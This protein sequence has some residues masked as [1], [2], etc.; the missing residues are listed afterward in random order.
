[1]T[2]RDRGRVRASGTS[3]DALQQNRARAVQHNNEEIHRLILENTLD[4]IALID[5]TGRY[6]YV[7]PSH[8]DVLGYQPA[9]LIGSSF[10]EFVHPLDRAALMEQWPPVAGEA[11]SQTMLRVYHADG[12]WRS[13][14]TSS[15]MVMRQGEPH[16]VWLARDITA[17]QQSGRALIRLHRHHE[18]ILTSA[19]EGIFG[20]DRNGHTTFANPA[21]AR[22]LGW[23]SVDLLGQPMHALIHHTK[24]DGTAYPEA[25]CPIFA[26]L[27]E[28]RVYHLTDD[29]F[30]RK[31]GT[32]FPVE[33]TST[34]IYEGRMI[35]GAVV[36]F[37]NIRARK[38]LEARLLHTQKMDSIG[39]L[40][41]GVAHDFN[42]LLTVIIGN[43]DLAKLALAADAHGRG[44]LGEIKRAA[45]RATN[46][47]GQLLA[48]ARKQV[49]K[50]RIVNLNDLLLDMDKLLRRLI[51][52]HIELITL[53]SV[54]LGLI[55]ADPGQLEQVIVNLAVN[56]RDAMPEGG[57]L[58][59]ATANVIIDPVS[60]PELTASP[61]GAYVLL[62]I[63][64]TGMGMSED[65]KAR[66]FEP[67][68]T[69]KA[70]G[71]GTG[72]GLATCYG[73]ITQQGGHIQIDS[74]VGQGTAISIY[75]PLVEAT[76]DELS[77]QHD[78]GTLPLGQETVLLVEDEPSVRALARRVL[79]EQGYSVL[80]AANGD[81]ALQLARQHVGL[82]I[83]LLLTDVV[84]PQMS[85][86]A[87]ANQLKDMYPAIK[88]LFTSG[89]TD[90]A[91]I[92]H[93]RLQASAAFLAKPFSPA[94]LACAM[95]EVL[96]SSIP[97]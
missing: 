77:Q 47:T 64:D 94:I 72:L 26:T 3:S 35:T 31:D 68:F 74:Q 56:A 66:A 8:L 92:R 2:G 46:L 96:D 69:T 53:L 18:L 34:P 54:D 76:A 25:D 73:I 61:T 60:V 11:I 44:E 19:G 1:M 38:D 97:A 4:L 80:E 28:G 5:R 70:P 86:I 89:Y 42:N 81:E 82:V 78:E 58:T 39:R 85:G 20:V 40:A 65:V 15:R 9:E 16:V 32:S 24:P 90:D 84:M 14:E 36:V 12:A 29:V 13:F 63:S 21:A 17:Q 51:D 6:V 7:S 91:I 88:I 71:R 57:K 83:D 33:Y 43:A 41:G 87:L 48:F 50:P 95:R 30:W 22:L 52:E 10:F 55:K 49:I 93:A 45:L 62:T 59:L 23:E 67:F 37:R 27:T 79:R 75:L